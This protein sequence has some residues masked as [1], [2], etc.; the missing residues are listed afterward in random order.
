MLKLVAEKA[1]KIL[2]GESRA[3]GK[4]LAAGNGVSAHT[5]GPYCGGLN[6]GHGI[7]KG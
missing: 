2:S 1:E 4:H 6:T 7:G 5:P 3:Q